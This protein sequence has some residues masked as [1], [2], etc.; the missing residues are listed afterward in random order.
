MSDLKRKDVIE[1]DSFT[2][3]V[4]TGVPRAIRMIAFPFSEESE[5]YDPEFEIKQKDMRTSFWDKKEKSKMAEGLKSSANKAAD[6]LNKAADNIKTSV[7]DASDSVKS[8]LSDK[9]KNYEKK[10]EVKKKEVEK[11]VNDYYNKSSELYGKKR[12]KLADWIHQGI[13]GHHVCDDDSCGR[14]TNLSFEE[15][16]LKENQFKDTKP[17]AN[18][19]NMTMDPRYYN[20]RRDQPLSYKKENGQWIQYPAV[21]EHPI[22]VDENDRVA[23]NK[24]YHTNNINN[25]G[26]NRDDYYLNNNK[27]N[28]IDSV[29]NGV[30]ESVDWTTDKA[31]TYANKASESLEKVTESVDSNWKKLWNGTKTY[32]GQKIENAGDKIEKL[33]HDIKMDGEIQKAK[34]EPKKKYFL[35]LF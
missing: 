12:G 20:W 29:K 33:G 22:Y 9:D 8:A 15:E 11:K 32:F 2:R 1:N 35:G 34:T 23:Y 5:I 16:I 17:F 24:W 25:N 30:A 27:T 18:F 28:Y 14:Q 6:S 3:G 4:E 21:P 13:F 19:F 31:K 26:Y 10:Y 7:K